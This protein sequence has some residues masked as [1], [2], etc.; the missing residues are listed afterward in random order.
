MGAIAAVMSAVLFLSAHIALVAMIIILYIGKSAGVL[1]D[2]I[3]TKKY[4]DS[5]T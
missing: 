1:K 5:L 4:E 2:P 3:F